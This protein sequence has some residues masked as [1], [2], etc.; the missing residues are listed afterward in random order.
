MWKLASDMTRCDNVSRR[1]ATPGRI[2]HAPAAVVTNAEVINLREL[3]RR[4]R[5]TFSYREAYDVE[6]SEVDMPRAIHMT[7]LQDEWDE[8]KSY[9][10]STCSRKFWKFFLPIHTQPVNAI[11]AALRSAKTTFMSVKDDDWKGFPPSRRSLL[12]KFDSGKAFWS[13]VGRY[14]KLTLKAVE[15]DLKDDQYWL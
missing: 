3:A 9:V 4:G 11:D 14:L 15:T 7:R 5:S 1:T 12:S 8:F 13:K 2:V 10:F 6:A